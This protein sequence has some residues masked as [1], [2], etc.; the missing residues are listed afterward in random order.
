[1]T[2]PV[3]LR[4]GR[5]SLWSWRAIYLGAPIALDPI[6]RADVEAGAAA[7]KTITARREVAPA[8]EAIGGPAV[9]ELLHKDGNNLPVAIVRLFMALKLASLAQGMSGVRW[10]VVQRILDC[11]SRDLLPAVPEANASDRL[12][13]SH[14]FGALTGT[15]GI[16]ADRRRPASQAL[17]RAGL[18]PMRLR[19]HERYALLS[20]THLST[21]LALAGLFEAER[22]LQSALVGAALSTA[23]ARQSNTLLHPRVHKLHRHPGQMEVASALRRVLAGSLGDNAGGSGSNPVEISGAARIFVQMGACLDLLR[24]AGTT[25][26]SAANA[27]CE[28]RLVLW[29][30]GEIVAGL[31]DTS[32]VTFAADQI[33]LALRELSKLAERRIAPLAAAASKTEP[34]HRASETALRSMA[35]SF[36][37]ENNERAYP[38]GFDGDGNAEGPA[39]LVR[40]VRRLLPMAGNAALVVAI[41]C[42]SAARA[43]ERDAPEDPAD[44]LAGARRLL[45]ERVLQS[46]DANGIP[47][48]D[49][50]AAADLVRSGALA[51]APGIELPAVV[52]P[53]A[54]T[55]PRRLAS[56]AMR[57]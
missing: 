25:L 8:Q 21:A 14:L 43:E 19:A 6:Y 23:T 52:R 50:A 33:A 30:S 15:G 5:V 44:E 26:E 41:E 16:D 48:A 13:L 55:S 29:Q 40:G 9:V 35:A 46:G 24:Q 45:R 38:T 47:A 17:R 22:V 28:D 57:N 20:G 42:L 51:A 4:P 39:P 1:M 12:A 10:K 7:L 37:A 3:T 18:G 49:L 54:E 36:T 11:L 2:D 32:P 31:E 27:V 53:P 56:R 34:V